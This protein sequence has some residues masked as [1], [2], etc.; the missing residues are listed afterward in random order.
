M[1]TD[2]DAPPELPGRRR[3]KPA[4]EAP[5]PGTVLAEPDL[6]ACRVRGTPERGAAGAD[7]FVS[8][9]A[10]PRWS[11]PVTPVRV[12]RAYAAPPTQYAAGHRGIDLAAGPGATVTAPS[13]G[14]VHFAGTVVDRP[15]LTLDVGGGVLASFEPV[16]T[17]LPDGTFVQRGEPIGTIA[18]GGHCDACLH[19]GVRVDGEYVSPLLFLDR[20]P[21][22]VLLPLERSGDGRAAKTRSG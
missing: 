15:V 7:A 6:A 14:R 16:A 17:D 2:G 5:A 12:T 10:P 4:A 13:A 1:A 11:W 20:L 9:A 3:V 8:D 22:S 18:A 21:P 19:L